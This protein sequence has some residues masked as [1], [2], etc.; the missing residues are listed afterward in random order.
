MDL[1]WERKLLQQEL[2]VLTFGF[3]LGVLLMS[4]GI[5]LERLGV[6]IS[7]GL[8]LCSYRAFPLCGKMIMM[9]LDNRTPWLGSPQATS[10]LN[11]RRN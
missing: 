4:K 6:S 1:F 7:G 9:C 8:F 2:V 3:L 11:L 10:A 5:K